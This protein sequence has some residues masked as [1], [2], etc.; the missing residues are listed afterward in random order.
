MT[1]PESA[2]PPGSPEQ[3]RVELTTTLDLCTRY[4]LPQTDEVRELLAELRSSS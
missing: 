2:E 1:S 4:G 3:A